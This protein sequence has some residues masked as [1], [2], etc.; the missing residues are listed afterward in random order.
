MGLFGTRMER[1]MWLADLQSWPNPDSPNGQARRERCFDQ[2]MGRVAAPFVPNGSSVGVQHR[3]AM[4]R[5]PQPAPSG[6]DTTPDNK[7]M[8]EVAM[9]AIVAML[10]L[11]I[12]K[13]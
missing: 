2:H 11:L 5:P 12:Y 9:V 1:C 7:V 6:G 3:G 13:M 10:I 8:S 4:V